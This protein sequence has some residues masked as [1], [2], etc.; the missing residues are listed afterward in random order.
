M[1]SDYYNTFKDPDKDSLFNQAK[2]GIAAAY[3]PLSGIAKNAVYD[4]NKLAEFTQKLAEESG[5]IMGGTDTTK[6]D[7]E[8]DA[9]EKDAIDKDIDKM[10]INSKS[11][12]SNIL[13]MIFKI[14][15]IGLNIV[16]RL[17]VL[18]QGMGDAIQGT[19][20]GIAGLGTTS[21][22]LFMDTYKFSYQAFIYTFIS[23]MC[24]FENLSQLNK[25]FIFYL[26]DILIIT[27]FVGIMSFLFIF[28]VFFFFVKKATG[29]GFVDSFLM[30]LDTLDSIDQAI[31]GLFG[32]HIFR[33]P[34]SIIRMCYTC[35]H[36][37]NTPALKSTLGKLNY[38]TGTLLPR[39]LGP[40]FKKLKSGGTKIMSVFKM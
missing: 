24:A 8:K 29:V 36:K 17:P 4:T 2:S 6:Q 10:K 25:C 3:A 12:S 22:Q 39:Q 34:D 11:S 18:A 30:L 5:A 16:S 38:D 23:I 33:Y 35:S 28:D 40:S 26:V 37:Y 9:A 7:L 20:T 14:V 32:F 13:A 19:A 1:I 27:V 15:P 31:Y 21:F